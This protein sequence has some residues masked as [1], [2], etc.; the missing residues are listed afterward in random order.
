[1]FRAIVFVKAW[2]IGVTPLRCKIG[3]GIKNQKQSKGFDIGQLAPLDR[4]LLLNFSQYRLSLAPPVWLEDQ[5]DR[6]QQGVDELQ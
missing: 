3:K 4:A 5:A 2:A 1:M 6:Q